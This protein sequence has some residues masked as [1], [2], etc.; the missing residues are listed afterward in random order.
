MRSRCVAILQ[1][2]LKPDA[3]VIKNIAVEINGHHLKK[4]TGTSGQRNIPWSDRFW[5][6][7]NEPHR[8]ANQCAPNVRP[9]FRPAAW[10]F[11]GKMENDIQHQIFFAD[12]EKGDVLLKTLAG[13]LVRRILSACEP[14][15]PG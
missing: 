5:F 12:S 2:F 14:V 1:A 9:V 6:Q 13:D 7:V 10:L 15:Q 11:Q 3:G 8:G 4:V